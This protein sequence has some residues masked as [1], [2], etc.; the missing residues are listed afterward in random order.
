MTKR[1]STTADLLN[2]Y[3][4]QSA[5][6]TAGALAS[7]YNDLP[8]DI[9]SLCDAIHGTMIHMFWIGENTY[10]ITHDQ[11]KAGGRKIC[12]EFSYSS[13]EERLQNIMDLADKPL[14]EPR[15]PCLRS[16]GCCRDYAL[17]LTSILRHKGVPARVR[18]G[19]ALYFLSPDA[20]LFEDHY[21]TEHWNAAESRW[22]LTDP[23]I[24]DVQRPAIEKGLNIND[25]PNGV[26]LTGWQLMEG[27]R[28]ENVPKSVGFPPA[29]TGFTY[30]RNKLFA[31]FVSV[32]GHELPVHAWWGIGHPKSVKSGDDEL[33]D[34]MIALLQGID[35][36]DPAALDEAL[37]LAASHERL[38]MP[39]GYTVETYKSPFC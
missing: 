39:E 20:P 15:E 38:K 1:I 19:V 31:D 34:L 28:A 14:S 35:A 10:G 29:N 8:D 27:L 17:V 33:I 4:Q 9:P 37:Q 25:L 30:G 12:V 13:V 16:V 32:T 18:T 2:Y 5:Y 7:L 11:L 21:I 26:F 36:N 6:S 23:Q 3:R 24:D 22:Q